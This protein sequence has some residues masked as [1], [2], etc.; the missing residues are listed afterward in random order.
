MVVRRLHD[1]ITYRLDLNVVA[2]SRAN[3]LALSDMTMCT[4]DDLLT[5]QTASINQQMDHL[6][7]R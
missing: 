4:C 5:H 3:L 7:A 1:I 2:M 6:A